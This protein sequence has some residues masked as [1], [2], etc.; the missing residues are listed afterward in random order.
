MMLT[1]AGLWLKPGGT[2]VFS[3]CSLEPAEGEAHLAH[4]P[5]PLDPVRADELPAGIAPHPE[6]YVRTGPATLAEKG[7]LD[8]FFI[9]RFKRG[10]A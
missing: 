7:A 5:F 6:G 8:G 10:R 1:R 4:A 9:A 2:L 3:T